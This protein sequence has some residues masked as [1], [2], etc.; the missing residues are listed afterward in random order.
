MAG[1]SS[2]SGFIALLD[3]D[4]VILQEHALKQLNTFS[5]QFWPEI[6]DSLKRIEELYESPH[7]PA[8]ELAAL[9]ASKVYYHLGEFSDAMTYALAAG[10]LFNLAEDSQYVQ[11]L[12]AKCVDE[13][14]RLARQEIEKQRKERTK[15]RAEIDPETLPAEEEEEDDICLQHGIIDQKLENI[16]ERMFDQCFEDKEFKQALGIAVESMRLDIVEKAIINSNDVKGMLQYCYEV[17]TGLLLSRDWRR[18]LL[19]L[20]VR[21]Y[22]SSNLLDYVN[23]SRCLVFL[24]KSAAIAQSFDE[25]LKKE[26]EDQTLLVFQ[27]G[28]ELVDN[29]TQQF[30]TAVRAAL[31]PAPEDSTPPEQPSTYVKNLRTLHKILEGEPTISFNLKFMHTKNRADLGLL[32]KLKGLF[33]PRLSVLHTGTIVA[34]AIMHCGTLRDTFLRENLD[35][36]SKAINWAKFTTTAGLGVIHRGHVKEAK[37]VMDPYLPKPGLNASPYTEGGSLFAMGLIFANHGHEI[38]DYLLGQLRSI[39]NA[40]PEADNARAAQGVLDASQKKEIVQHGAALGLGVAAM[41]SGNKEMFNELKNILYHHDSAVAGEAAGLAMGL[42]MLGTATDMSNEL[43]RF[44]HDTQHEKVIRALGLGLALIMYGLEERADSMI[45]TL[46]SDKDPI[47]R[48]GGQFTIGLA[49][50]GTANNKAIRQLLHVAVS[51]VSDDVRRAAVI[52]LGFVLFRQPEQVPKLVSLLAESYNP[53][54]RYGA[55]IALG[56]ACSGT[57]MK[58]A[59]TLLEPMTRDPVPFVRQGAFIALAMVLIQVSEKIEPKVKE[60]RQQFLDTVGDKHQSIVAKLGAIIALGII[61]AGGRNVTIALTSRAGHINLSAVVGLMVFTQYWYWYPFFLFISLAFTPTAIIALNANL[62][63]PKYKIKSNAK[64]SLFAYPEEVKEEKEKE[65][66]ALPTA[67]LSITKK[68]QLR[69]EKKKQ[70]HKDGGT[71]MEIDTRESSP[72]EIEEKKEQKDPKPA[73]EE[74]PEP[75]FEILNNP[76]RVTRAQLPKITFDVDPRY[77]PITEGIHGIVMLK[78]KTPGEKEDIIPE[79]LPTSA[80]VLEDEA[81]EPEPPEPFEFLGK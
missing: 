43:L 33:E 51:D 23:M 22:Q 27:I 45:E 75:D 36:L 6:A 15:Q 60:I 41:A 50:C 21:L 46:N 63:M 37:N 34:N 64:P 58:E 52:A 78:D 56:I 80:G 29:A 2:A 68:V 76:A 24:N 69:Q 7:F 73:A 53:N 4:D 5:E 70:Q 61:D 9:V 25:L 72:M 8:R 32:N 3:E 38:S 19:R 59:I 40:P 20:L 48:Y 55:A 11:T 16:V 47:L 74:K 42:V 10:K 1:I 31:P 12:T 77:V 66:K 35:W 14:S 71:S 54:V 81:N 49:Y 67:Q 13:Y 79:T 26:N 18:S 17:S 44:A 30:L 57:G 65:K 28:F 62:E 39:E